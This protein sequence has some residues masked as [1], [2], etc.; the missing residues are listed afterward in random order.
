VKFRDVPAAAW[1]AAA[2]A[3]PTKQ[4]VVPDWAPLFITLTECGWVVL[5]PSEEDGR[6]TCN[7]SFESKLFKDFRNWAM[8]NRAVM[9]NAKRIG[10]H[11]WFVTIGNP[12]KRK[13]LA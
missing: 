5:E 1:S 12:Y 4:I 9:L 7:G 3:V 6:T 11:R 2:T 13:E 10:L 8:N